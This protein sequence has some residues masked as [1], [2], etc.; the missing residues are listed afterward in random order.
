MARATK[1]HINLP[2]FAD[3]RVTLY[4]RTDVT[5]SG[6][7]MR[8]YL[9]KEARYYRKGLKTHDRTEAETLAQSELFKVLGRQEAGQTILSISVAKLIQD[10][11]LVLQAQLEREE[12]RPTTHKNAARR[13][14]L[15]RDFL[16]EQFKKP[17]AGLQTKL[18]TVEGA[19]F[20]G[21]LDWRR[22]SNPKIR[23]DVVQ[24]ELL[25]IK[26]MFTW[27]VKKK[28]AGEKT[29]PT[30][31]FRIEKEKAKREDMA[32]QDSYSLLVHAD[33]WRNEET[34]P[35]QAY[36]RDLM[37]HVLAVLNC[38]GMRT[39][40]VLQLPKSA[41]G[42]LYDELL[43][44]VKVKGTN[45]KSQKTR[46]ITI[47]GLISG[48]TEAFRNHNYLWD[49]MTRVSMAVQLPDG[50]PVF[51]E[52]ELVFSTYDGEK[53][54]NAFYKAYGEFR[55]YLKQFKLDHLDPYHMRHAFI[56]DRLRAGV[57]PIDIANHCGT[58]IRM[59]SQTYSHI[60]GPESSRRIAAKPYVYKIT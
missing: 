30:W 12:M 13:I 6:W 29:I 34:T 10:Y 26:K 60:T 41:V 16:A 22:S 43:C 51:K 35:I 18:S 31:N 2:R 8:V 25:V 19:I 44:D 28:L 9:K 58:S 15:A 38:S 59:I 48:P 42:K 39:G 36:N 54:D 21:Y 37:F 7:H 45:S 5:D 1:D 56:S 20:E 14:N 50:T 53:P 57:Y 27:A 49:W 33:N 40:E 11:L 52:S 24:Q 23:R 47:G 4:R 32:E 3:H 55:E 17:K 46:T